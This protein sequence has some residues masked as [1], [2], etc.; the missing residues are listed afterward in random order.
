[1][2]VAIA[3][4]GSVLWQRKQRQQA[5]QRARYYQ[6]ARLNTLGEI[7]AGIVHEINQPLTAVQ[8]SIQG[9]SDSSRLIRRPCRRRLRPRCCKRNASAPC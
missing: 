5:E 4:V 7:T 6:H 8:T 2:G 3:G 9:R 1:M